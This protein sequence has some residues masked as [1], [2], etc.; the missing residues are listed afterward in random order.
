MIGVVSLRCNCVGNTRSP[1]SGVLRTRVRTSTSTGIAGI[2]RPDKFGW[3][4]RYGGQYV[5]DTVIQ[6]LKE[7]EREYNIAK[8]D[9]SFQVTPSTTTTTYYLN[10]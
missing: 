9:K 8:T 7:L 6:N 10:V 2:E 4:G 3:F 1:S 5:P